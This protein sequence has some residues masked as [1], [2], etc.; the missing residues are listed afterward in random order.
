LAQ[1]RTAQQQAAFQNYIQATQPLPGQFGQAPSTAGQFFQVAEQAIP[2]ALTN[3]FNELYRS[4]ANYQASTY[5]AQ[6]SAIAS[7][8]QS[9]AQTFGAIASGISGFIPSFSFS[10]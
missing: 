7:S 8:Y 2:V 6:T 3:A 5:G 1:A 9:P 4:Q 10:R